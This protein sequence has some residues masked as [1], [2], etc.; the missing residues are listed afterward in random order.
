MSAD[1]P[2]RLRGSTSSELCDANGKKG[3]LPPGIA[4][5]SGVGVVA[6]PA[7]TVRC[8]E[9]SVKGVFRA[10][11][12]VRAGQVLVAQGPGPWAYLGDLAGAEAVRAGA[13]AVVI[14]GFA[15]DLETIAR[16]ELALF[17]R[18]TTPRGALARGPGELSVPLVLG[19]TV[20]SPGDWVVGDRD[21]L[22]AISPHAVEGVLARAAEIAA[23]EQRT[24]RAMR[25][26]T[27]LLDLPYQ[28]GESTLRAQLNTAG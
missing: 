21:G 22:V 4:R 15:R 20:V 28:G 26:G 24:R 9:G 8:Q 7:F 1:L 12:E 17:A 3:V 13:V 19:E 14:D 2:E 18:G 10:L 27:S 6:G 5:L 16:T 25:D 11:A 23:A